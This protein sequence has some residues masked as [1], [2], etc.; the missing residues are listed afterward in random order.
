MAVTNVCNAMELIPYFSH[1]P[2]ASRRKSQA[3][4]PRTRAMS[5]ISC[6]VRTIVG[7]CTWKRLK[8]K[9]V[10]IPARPPASE[11]QGNLPNKAFANAKKA[12]ISVIY[13]YDISHSANK[14]AISKS[15]QN[16]YLAFNICARGAMERIGHLK[17]YRCH[18][19][20]P[21]RTIPTNRIYDSTKHIRHY[22]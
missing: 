22:A 1:T 12:P 2:M 9:P 21:R 3:I 4:R 11:H 19:L 14:T 7:F 5:N 16:G 6:I 8:M 10:R 17:C 18:E 15:A 13:P 20:F